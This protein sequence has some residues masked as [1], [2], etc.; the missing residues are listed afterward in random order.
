MENWRLRNVLLASNHPLQSTVEFHWLALVG[1]RDAWQEKDPNS[2]THR[3]SWGEKTTRRNEKKLK[4]NEIEIPSR[5]YKV[6]LRS[7]FLRSPVSCLFIHSTQFHLLA[8]RRRSMSHNVFNAF[9]FEVDDGDAASIPTFG[10]SMLQLQLQLCRNC[11]PG[12]RLFLL[13]GRV[14]RKSFYFV[15]SFTREMSCYCATMGFGR[16]RV[17]GGGGGL[18]NT[19]EE[20]CCRCKKGTG[21]SEIWSR[22]T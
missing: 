3:P 20:V 22:I 11:L 5:N 21:R 7:L 1:A 17:R 12:L 18:K 8:S 14:N 13:V 2:G 4:E 6:G 10:R 16:C 9:P 15:S 19:R